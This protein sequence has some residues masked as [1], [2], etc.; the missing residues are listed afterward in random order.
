MGVSTFISIYDD[1]SSQ[2][3]VTHKPNRHFPCHN[4]NIYFRYSILDTCHRTA[5]PFVD[6]FFISVFVSILTVWWQFQH[7][8]R[9]WFGLQ[10][11]S[12]P[13]TKWVNDG[14]I[15]EMLLN[16]SQ[17]FTFGW[18]FTI[19]FLSHNIY[20]TENRKRKAVYFKGSLINVRHAL[21]ILTS[22]KMID[23]ASRRV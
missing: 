8:Q 7:V 20:F 18:T 13:H 10:I 17:L 1:S 9:L 21:F 2:F 22:W 15:S 5:S 23:L 19:I 6:M 12:I 16:H 11:T 3:N 14:Y 4:K